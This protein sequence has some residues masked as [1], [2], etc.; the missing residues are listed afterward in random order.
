[1]FLARFAYK[2]EGAQIL[3][4]IELHINLYDNKNLMES[5]LYNFVE[6]SQLEHQIQKKRLKTVVGDFIKVIQW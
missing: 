6:R 2:D 1:M 3:D 4:E 5:G